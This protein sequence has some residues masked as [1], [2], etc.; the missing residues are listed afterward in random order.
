ME[1]NTKIELGELNITSEFGRLA[2]NDRTMDLS[3]Q[4]DQ[5]A[6]SN[7]LNVF[8]KYEKGG[9]KLS[10]EG[11]LA[12]AN[13]LRKTPSQ[14][15]TFDGQNQNNNDISL[16]FDYLDEN[17]FC[18]DGYIKNLEM[19]SRL[20]NLSEWE[21][22]DNDISL[23][24]N[25]NK[26]EFF[27]DEPTENF[28]EAE[29]ENFLDKILEDNDENIVSVKPSMKPR[30]RSN[31]E[32]KD[33]TILDNKR[34]VRIDLKELNAG[35]NYEKKYADIETAESKSIKMM[36]VDEFTLKCEYNNKKIIDMIKKSQESMVKDFQ[37]NRL[38][39]IY[40]T[41]YKTKDKGKSYL[42]YASKRGIPKIID[43]LIKEN[44]D[45]NLQND[46]GETAQFYCARKGFNAMAMH[47]I[48][49]KAKITTLDNENRNIIH[50][51][52][53][54]NNIEL[55]SFLLKSFKNELDID[56]IDNYKMGCLDYA[57]E[58]P[59]L[60]DLLRQ[61]GAKDNSLEIGI[62]LTPSMKIDKIQGIKAQLKNKTFKVLE[63]SNF[64]NGTDKDVKH[65]DFSVHQMIG[66][67]S[68]GEVYLVEHKVTKVLY[69]M[70]VFSKKTVQAQNLMRFLNV[71]KKIMESYNHPFLVKLYYA[72][73][74]FKKLYL[75][76]HFC[77]Y[78]DI[79]YLLRRK[80]YFPENEAKLVLAEIIVAVESLHD[81]NI[82][83]RDLKPDNVLVDI[84]GHIKVTDFGLAKEGIDKNLTRTFCGSIAYLPPEVIKKTGHNKSVD[85]YLCG[86]ILFEMLTGKPPYFSTN[87]KQL[88]HN[89]LNAKLKFPENVSPKARDLIKNQL[90]RNIGDRLGSK[91]DASELK[92]HPFFEGLD[93][94][95]LY[96]KDH[97]PPFDPKHLRIYRADKLYK[98]IEDDP[99][100][101]G[102]VIANWSFV[103]N[104]K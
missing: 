34:G 92:R 49:R 70:K 25:S 77:P 39:N 16:N 33:F 5:G 24:E 23:N 62:N 44:I 94:E 56:K 45:I 28:N 74:T 102:D 7:N 37:R 30:E 100:E 75:I 42:H 11:K 73:Q 6:N 35:Q 55:A 3:P 66:K 46:N 69:A 99:K 53:M 65:T 15:F 89:I 32:K 101:E 79:G 31:T 60:S 29:N 10:N 97:P 47:L 20:L 68:F 48:K 51:C 90:K 4:N 43:T 96:A 81:K 88:T 9:F 80:K 18:K 54:Y 61:F 22:S 14:K 76:M 84:D 98:E 8:E 13:K 1:N 83:H 93:W 26:Q 12:E 41:N 38:K 63:F 50:Y 52:A 64:N 91:K 21:V 36:N 27:L 104:G 82:I 85:W 17:S 72:F 58:N 95:K 40:E 57:T 19:Q 86:L 103:R 87:Y 2:S 71:E 59:Q 67:G 78:R